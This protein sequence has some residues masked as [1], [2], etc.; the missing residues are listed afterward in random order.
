[1]SDLEFDDNVTIVFPGKLPTFQQNG[2]L[3]PEKSD[4]NFSFLIPGAG[5]PCQP[6]PATGQQE[7][8][9]SG[10]STG[11]PVSQSDW[12]LIIPVCHVMTT[13]HLTSPHL[14]FEYV[15]KYIDSKL[16]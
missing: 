12:E 7:G 4:F 10:D 9:Q 8:W 13:P 15:E 3:C 11:P 5:G 16:V 14:T 2:Q 6:Q 1:M